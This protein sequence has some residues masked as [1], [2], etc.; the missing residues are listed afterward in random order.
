MTRV[1]YIPSGYKRIYETF[2]E[3][4]VQ[5]LSKLNIPHVVSHPFETETSFLTKITTFRPTIMI[6]M[7]GDKLPLYKLQYLRKRR[8]TC[9]VW[10]TEDPYYT[11]R[12]LTYIREYDAVMSIEANSVRFYKTFHPNVLHLP[13]G[14]NSNVFYKNDEPAQHEVSFVGYPYQNRLDLLKLIL[15]ETPHHVT[16]VGKWKKHVAEHLASSRLHVHEGWFPPRTIA[17]FYRRSKINLNTLRDSQESMNENQTGIPNSSI[18]NRTFDIASCGSFQLLP[19]IEGLSAAFEIGKEIVSYQDEGQLL[20]KL[21]YYLQNETERQ[22]I[23]QQAMIRAQR[24]HTF[25]AR[26]QTMIDFINTCKEDHR[27]SR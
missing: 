11:D 26:V 19:H 12:T 23:A 2:D 18:N 10:L 6:T 22:D 1:L 16:V 14:T 24:D 9:G 4:F 7:V 20:Q 27:S 3:W 17:S 8:I 5:A 15:Q 21:A 25:L 13:L